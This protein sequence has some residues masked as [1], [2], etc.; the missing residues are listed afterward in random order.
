[1]DYSN[2]YKKQGLIFKTMPPYN[3]MPNRS[4]I[5]NVPDY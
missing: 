2:A 5:T 1:M 4:I 3:E